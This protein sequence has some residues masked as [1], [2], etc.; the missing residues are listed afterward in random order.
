MFS[1]C[2]CF[3][4]AQVWANTSPGGK[5]H[6]AKTD[7]IFSA[8]PGRARILTRYLIS[9]VLYSTSSMAS[10]TLP[11]ELWL[12]VFEYAIDHDAQKMPSF[13]CACRQFWSLA[14]KHKPLWAHV[15]IR[16]PIARIQAYL[17]RSEPLGLLVCTDCHSSQL[18]R[19]SP[20]IQDLAARA[21]AFSAR[22]TNDVSLTILSQ[23]PKL[24]AVEILFNMPKTVSVWPNTHLLGRLELLK[25]FFGL[26]ATLPPLPALEMLILEDISFSTDNGTP[27]VKAM[28]NMPKLQHFSLRCGTCMVVPASELFKNSLLTLVLDSTPHV[29]RSWLSLFTPPTLRLEIIAHRLGETELEDRSE[30]HR[31]I[32]HVQEA[33]PRLSHTHIGDLEDHASNQDPWGL[34]FYATTYIGCARSTFSASFV[35][36]YQGSMVGYQLANVVSITL[37]TQAVSIFLDPRQPWQHLSNYLHL[38]HLLLN[39]SK[40][41]S[42]AERTI[43]VMALRSLRDAR[44]GQLLSN[45]TL[46][47]E[48]PHSRHR[49]PLPISTWSRSWLDTLQQYLVNAGVAATVAVATGEE[50]M[51]SKWA[52]VELTYLHHL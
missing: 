45:L 10:F 41:V 27:L 31:Y 37:P 25:V 11:P 39:V 36:A 52:P 42:I 20:Q 15:N 7:T 19:D 44:N 17:N 18:H 50:K 47:Y 1:H 22:V 24:K 46:C 48:D 2:L 4:K 13:I 38:D 30:I 43:L 40:P 9:N 26:G 35:T 5:S 32:Q 16:W 21:M 29:V 14:L 23:A 49:H 51:H 8:L 28:R 3:W 34:P 12:M 33:I 6:L